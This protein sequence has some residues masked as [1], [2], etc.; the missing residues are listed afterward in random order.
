VVPELV[1]VDDRS[2]GQRLHDALHQV[3]RQSLQS[4]DLPGCGG[5]PATVLITMT[6]EQFETRTGLATTGLGQR[7]TINQALRL[8]GWCFSARGGPR[9]RS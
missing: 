3:C 7:L 2:S 1:F 6:A 4:G 8:G 9:S 5:I